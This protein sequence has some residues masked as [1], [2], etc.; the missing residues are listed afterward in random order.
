MKMRSRT[1]AVWLTAFFGVAVARV[2]LCRGAEPP[3][4]PQI[5]EVRPRYEQ[6]KTTAVNDALARCLAD[7]A[8][9]QNELRT[10]YAEGKVKRF[11]GIQ[12]MWLA[13]IE[14]TN[15]YYSM[16]FDSRTG[17]L[18]SFHKFVYADK[19]RTRELH[20][21]GYEIHYY[22][23]GPVKEYR[24]RTLHDGLDFY[25]NGGLKSFRAEIDDRTACEASW[26]ADGKLKGE[27]TSSHPPGSEEGLPELE[28]QLRHG[29]SMKKWE[30]AGTM[31][32][33][34]PASIPYALN[35]LKDGDERSRERAATVFVLLGEKAAHA[36]PDLSRFLRAD[37][38]AKV[39]KEIAHAL[40]MVGP[41]AKSA[42][43]AL[44]EAATNDVPEVASTAKSALERIRGPSSK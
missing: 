23:D 1:T 19:E 38:S 36:V 13:Y 35:V 3:Q 9:A 10:L 14:L 11:L 4:I 8:K 26:D 2:I 27:G 39:R 12:G 28:K 15:G 24:R 34:G 41:S 7:V 6:P 31:A 42:I 43:P 44:E 20:D 5:A 40:L 16:V 30:A 21:L 18:L 32:E 37:E 25:P 17:P 22:P 29:D 33:I